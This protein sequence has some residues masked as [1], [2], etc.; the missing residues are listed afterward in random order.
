MAMDKNS[1]MSSLVFGIGK[2]NIIDFF[3]SIILLP[4]RRPY[5]LANKLPIAL[6]TDIPSY[7]HF[8]MH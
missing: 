5:A 1:N 4:P 6:P 7:V 2:P 8:H 3:F